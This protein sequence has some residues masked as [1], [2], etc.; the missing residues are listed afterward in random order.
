MHLV[1]YWYLEDSFNM[2]KRLGMRTMMSLCE[3]LVMK[4]YR[5]GQVVHEETEDGNM[6]YFIKEGFVKIGKRNE[7]GEEFLKYVLG[8]GHIFGEM[9]LISGEGNEYFAYAMD[10]CKICFIETDRME[11]MMEAYPRLHNSILKISCLKFNKVERRLDDLLY[12][13][14]ET[15]IKEFLLEYVQEHGELKDDEV[16]AK[17]IFS[18]KDI[19]K[20]TS[21]SRQTVNNVVSALRKLGDIT[22]DR[23]QISVKR[24]L[25]QISQIL[26]ED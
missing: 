17:N 7:E 24:E 19:A 8:K 26:T 2:M 4:S 10:E 3:L 1:K 11:K 14:A 25:L 15:R 23:K 22:Y 16:V 18:Q 21:T 5:K 9:K 20:L 13:D 6:I 12:K